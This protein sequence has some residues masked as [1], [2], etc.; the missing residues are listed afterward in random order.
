MTLVLSDEA[1][2]KQSTQSFKSVYD[3]K[4]AAFDAFSTH[5][6]IGSLDFFVALSSISGLVGLRGQ[7]NYARY[8]VRLTRGD[9]GT[10]TS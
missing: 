6:D 2:F 7:S 5:V 9:Q 3:S 10:H 8:V 1:F 4:L